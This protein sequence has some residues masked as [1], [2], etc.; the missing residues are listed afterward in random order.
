MAAAD[1]LDISVAFDAAT[2]PWPGDTPFTCGWAW[3]IADGASVNVSRWQTSPHVGTHADAPVHVMQGGA[4][5]DTLPLEPFLGKC[6][7]L[8]VSARSAA[9]SPEDLR[10]AGWREGTER[11]LLK[12]GASTAGGRFPDSWPALEPDTA[13]HLARGGL[14]LL[15]VDCPSVDARESKDLAVHH[16]LFAAG[17]FVLENLDLR[18]VTA[19]RY[20]LSAAPLKVA[21]CDAAPARALL[22]PL[23]ADA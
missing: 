6:L 7:L 18:R 23:S 13:Q 9:L 11:L 19:G 20:E 16:A 2:P 10:S 5:A 21:A 15:G 22:R 4:G 3:A 14:K 12:T 1:W 8:D 17:C